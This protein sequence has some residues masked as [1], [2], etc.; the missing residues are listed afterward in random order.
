MNQTLYG[1]LSRY[2]AQNVCVRVRDDAVTADLIVLLKQTVIPY[3]KDGKSCGKS[4]QFQGHKPP[5]EIQQ[6]S[7]L[8]FCVW[9]APD[10]YRENEC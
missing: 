2:A 1:I 8:A 3:S 6:T 7:Q 4:R 5:Y 10:T 9:A